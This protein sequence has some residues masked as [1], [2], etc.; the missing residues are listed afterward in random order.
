M[1]DHWFDVLFLLLS[2]ILPLNV[3]CRTAAKVVC[4]VF[5]RDNVS[6]PTPSTTN[7]GGKPPNFYLDI[8]PLDSIYP[9]F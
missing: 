3:F 8:R 7:Y 9:S 5:F 2:V 1:L 6:T 4:S